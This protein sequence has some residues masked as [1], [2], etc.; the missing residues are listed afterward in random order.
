M[1]KKSNIILIVCVLLTMLVLNL[2]GFAQSEPKYG[3]TLRYAMEADPAGLDLQIVTSDTDT[4]ISQHVFECLY[5]LNSK[6]EPVPY[7]VESSE[8][9]DDG[10]LVVLH[11]REGVLFHNGEEMTSEDVVASLNRW[12]KYGMRGGIFLDYIDKIEVVDRYTVN[13]HF[14]RV[15]G[16]WKVLL[17][18]HNAGPVIMPKDI[19]DAAGPEPVGLADLIGTGPY[20]FKKWE[21]GGSITLER[22]DDY[23]SRDEEPD[24]YAGRRTAYIDEIIFTPVTDPVTRRNGVIAGDYD[25]AF[26]IPGDFY[27]ELKED[28]RVVTEIVSAPLFGGVFFNSRKGIFKDN[29]KLREAIA[30]AI[31]H[32]AVMLAATGQEG[33][34][35]VNGSM[36]P[37]GTAYY[38]EA[39]ID[40]FNR[41]DPELARQLAKEAGYNGE[42]IRL[43][44]SSRDIHYNSVYAMTPMLEEAG[45]NIKLGMY[46]WATL[47]T[48]RPK[49]DLWD[50]F[51]TTSCFMPDPSLFTWMSPDYPGWWQTEERNELVAKLNKA[52]DI[53][54]RAEIWGEI[55]ALMYEQYPIIKTGDIYYYSIYSPKVHADKFS[56]WKYFWNAWLEE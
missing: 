53:A 44:F 37:P 52:S 42:E 27:N 6:I 32:E 25:W 34:Y 2:S 56:Y 3:G 43:I 46:D 47:V 19:M 55:Q 26:P 1:F 31:D 24:G 54:E 20:K 13:M 21:A 50:I 23:S 45:F 41:N 5:T 33:L 51:F 28:P 4:V 17:A 9:K 30:A 22:F 49:E 16:T 36:Y 15:L 11:L 38:S 12:G 40:K 39:G 18:F 8:V 14:K 29:Y 48:L 35:A 7:L 10:K